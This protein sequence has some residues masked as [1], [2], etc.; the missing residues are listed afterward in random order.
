MP[1]TLKSC[2]FEHPV[3]RGVAVDPINSHFHVLCFD[4]LAAGPERGSWAE[5]QE[6]WN[7]RRGRDGQT[8]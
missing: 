5:A 6:A 4:C 1:S 2:P 7:Q 3:L 8:Q